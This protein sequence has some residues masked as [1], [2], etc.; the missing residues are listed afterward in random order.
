MG[1]SFTFHNW[2]EK[3][4]FLNSVAHSWSMWVYKILTYFFSPS[5]LQ[6]P[7]ADTIRSP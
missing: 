3:T 2:P 5:G 7:Q 1:M 6:L 4:I